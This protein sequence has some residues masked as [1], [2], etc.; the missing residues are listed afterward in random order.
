MLTEESIEEFYREGFIVV[1][2]LVGPATV[3]RVLEAGRRCGEPTG[4]GWSARVFDQNQP[5]RDREIHEILWDEGVVRA[6]E[7]IFESEPRVWYGML[8]VVPANGG[9][10]L[11]WHQ[12]NQYTQLLGGAL[13][14]FVALT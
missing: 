2:G 14:V 12:D 1:R 9:D 8:A 10:G 13:N 5:T 4:A 11:P 3:A 6:V 7:Q